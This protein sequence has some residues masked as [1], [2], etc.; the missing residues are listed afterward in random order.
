MRRRLGRC[1]R[2]GG[3]ACQSHDNSRSAA[4][5][6]CGLSQAL[7]KAHRMA[8]ELATA[9]TEA[10]AVAMEVAGVELEAREAAMQAKLLEEA[11]K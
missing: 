10:S 7:A 8:R 9:F 2:D 4:L 3:G 11:V 5:S 6:G 1:G